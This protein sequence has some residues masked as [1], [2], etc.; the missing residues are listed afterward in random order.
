MEKVIFISV[1]GIYLISIVYFGIKNLHKERW[2]FFAVIPVRKVS[3]NQWIGMNITYYG[4]INGLA[5]IT[6]VYIFIFLTSGFDIPYNYIILSIILIL[7]IC[8]PASKIVA[9]IVE[10]KKNTFTVGGASFVG[11][12]ISP[13]V[14]LIIFNHYYQD[15]EKTMQI[16]MPVISVLSISYNLGEG[17]GRLACLSFGCCYGKPVKEL[18]GWFRRFFEIINVVFT[19]KT[20]KVSYASSLDGEPLVPVQGMAVILYVTTAFIGI[21]LFLYGYYITSFLITVMIGQFFRLFSEFF[22]ADYRGESKFSIYQWMSM[23]TIFY[24]L[25]IAFIFRKVVFVDHDIA[26]AF[27]VSLGNNVFILIIVIFFLVLVYTGLSKVTGS[28]ITFY[29]KEEE[30]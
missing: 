17:V 5:Y 14:F 30:I 10:G 3:D 29:V 11:S 23:I 8:M 22:R 7:S 24:S 1:L 16:L 12:I 18:N 20:K 15:I 28:K 2:Q 21:I 13:I 6:G 26:R 27:K 19:G 25:I 9:R 4:I